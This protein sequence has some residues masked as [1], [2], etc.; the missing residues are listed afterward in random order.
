MRNNKNIKEDEKYLALFQMLKKEEEDFSK[1]LFFDFLLEYT[2]PTFKNL[3]IDDNEKNSFWIVL[4]NGIY[5]THE[6]KIVK[7][8]LFW[9]ELFSR[10]T[11]DIRCFQSSVQRYFNICLKKFQ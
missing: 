11:A 5:E 9:K 6:V 4:I 8:I 10:E 3:W 7:E 1:E 2:K